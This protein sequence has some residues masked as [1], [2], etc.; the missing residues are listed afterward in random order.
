MDDDALWVSSRFSRSLSRAPKIPSS[1]IKTLSIF[2]WGAL[3]GGEI[4]L[5]VYRYPGIW[6]I[7][8]G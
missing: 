7:G 8:A 5:Q 6:V 2:F 1:I 3:R 4:L